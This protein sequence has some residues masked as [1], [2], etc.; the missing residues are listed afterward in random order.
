[1][2]TTKIIL[3]LLL[4]AILSAC[5]S[6]ANK[7]SMM[8]NPDAV[9]SYVKEEQKGKFVVDAVGGG[10]ATN[11]MWT[12]QVSKENFEA[13]LKDSLSI[14]GLTSA[15]S[16]ASQYKVDADLLSLQQPMFGLTF[17]VISTV[18]YRVHKAGFERKFPITAT[19]TATTS[20]AFVGMT[21]L[22]IANEKS[23]Q[24]NITEFIKQLSAATDIK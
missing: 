24:A 10:K 8:V 23:I 19:G 17:D 12:S 2:P 13:A 1:M 9:A 14:A 16:S 15:D 7:Q 3:L 6:P 5:A 18:N 22:K 21:R 11:P 20:D 4:V